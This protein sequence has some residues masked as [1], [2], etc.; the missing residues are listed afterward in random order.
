MC[1]IA[2]AY[3]SNSQKSVNQMVR[4]LKHRGPDG[5][6]VM[7]TADATLGHTRLAIVDVAG[8]GQPLQDGDA[9]IA[10][11]GEIYNYMDLRHKR[12]KGQHFKTRTDTE[13]V[14]RL[15]ER[16]GPKCVEL[17]NGMFAFAIAW[18]VVPG[19]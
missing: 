17:L 15:Y 2:G 1:G 8:G 3:Q 4:R 19:A 10:F 13:T 7:P 6:G 5:D 9:W 16:Y 11:N 14:L 18:R 12:L